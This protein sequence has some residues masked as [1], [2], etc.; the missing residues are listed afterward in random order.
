MEHIPAIDNVAI[1]LVPVKGA[2]PK[3]VAEPLSKV[4][5]DSDVIIPKE[6]FIL[7]MLPGTDEMGAIH[8][9]EG[10]SDFLSEVFK[11]VYAIY[12]QD[13]TTAEDLIEVL[14]ERAKRQLGLEI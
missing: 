1:A 5:R 7:L 12:P 11:F 8:V 10:V 14:K 13:G 6:N 3:K 9:L 2:D 4:L